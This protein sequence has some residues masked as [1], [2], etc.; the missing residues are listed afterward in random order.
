M[1]DI[2]EQRDDKGI[3]PFCEWGTGRRVR[4][5]VGHSQDMRDFVL[6]CCEQDVTIVSAIP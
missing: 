4:L 5:V 6:S 2:I 1:Q 3:S